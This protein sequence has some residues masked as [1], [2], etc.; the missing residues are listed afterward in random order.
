MSSA[1]YVHP[2]ATKKK[3]ATVERNIDCDAL[4]L[5][6]SPDLEICIFIEATHAEKTQQIARLFNQIFPPI[7]IKAPAPDTDDDDLPF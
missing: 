6:L 3:A 5:R 2:V 4:S 7:K 1:L